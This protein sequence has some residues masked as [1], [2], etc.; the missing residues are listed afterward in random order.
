MRRIAP[1]WT[2]MLAVAGLLLPGAVHL[3][4]VE[5]RSIRQQL[6]DVLNRQSATEER[7]EEIKEE[8][9]EAQSE[10][11]GA[12]NRAQ[13]ARD[14]A[15]VAKRHL[16][17]VREVLRQTRADLEQTEEELAGHQEAM[18]QRLVALY[19]TGQP[20]YL[21]VVLNATS[22]EDFTNRAEFSRLMAEQDQNLLTWLVE[23]EAKLDQQRRTLEVKQA[24]AVQLKQEQDAKK[25]VAEQAEAE[26]ES[27]VSKYRNDQ[28]AAEKMLAELEAA[29]NRL[30]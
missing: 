8:K 20:S 13:Q 14:E 15:A 25:R 30:E 28:A 12:R 18:S 5:A 2:A 17:E 26:A 22:F 3:D 9:A 19:E 6:R 29:E 23:T 27:L 24:E 10:L 16:E 7:L 4:D 11:A 21:E 1:V